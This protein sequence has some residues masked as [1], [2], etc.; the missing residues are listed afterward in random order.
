MNGRSCIDLQLEDCPCRS[1]YSGQTSCNFDLLYN[2][3]KEELKGQ[4]LL[5]LVC[6]SARIEVYCKENNVHLCCYPIHP[7]PC[8]ILHEDS[9][10][11]NF[12]NM[13]AELTFHQEDRKSKILLNTIC[14]TIKNEMLYHEF[15]AEDTLKSERKFLKQSKIGQK[16]YCTTE[17][18]NVILLQKPIE[19]GRKCKYKTSKGKIDEQWTFCFRTISG[20]GNLS[21]YEVKGKDYKKKAKYLEILARSNGFHTDTRELENSFLLKIFGD[22]QEEI[23]DFI[24]LCCDNDF[25]LY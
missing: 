23:D 10:F 12:G 20:G 14:H 3:Y 15:V 2:V 5:D 24:T 11:C 1:K 13:Y 6:V 21:K 7:C 19:V 16:V 17:C 22:F 9:L 4:D 18:N 8:K 25:V